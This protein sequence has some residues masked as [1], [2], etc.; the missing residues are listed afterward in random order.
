[1]TARWHGHEAELSARLPDVRK[2]FERAAAAEDFDVITV[3]VGEAVGLVHDVRPP[4]RSCIAWS[5]TPHE[6]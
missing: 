1:M 5:A 4:L 2:E 3:L 6:S